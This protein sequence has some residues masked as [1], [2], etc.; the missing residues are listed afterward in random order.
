ME[1]SELRDQIRRW[2]DLHTEFKLETIHPDDLSAEMVGF[3]NAD[4]GQ[5]IMGVSE[6]RQIVGLGDVDVL[7]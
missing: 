1:L 4:G 6:E 2:E 3:A 7:R 5:L